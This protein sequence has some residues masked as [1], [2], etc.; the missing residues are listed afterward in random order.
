MII[1]CMG[2][3]KTVLGVNP[4][5]FADRRTVEQLRHSDSLMEKHWRLRVLRNEAMRTIRAEKSIQP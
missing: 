2:R 5:A 4:V 3:T 1:V